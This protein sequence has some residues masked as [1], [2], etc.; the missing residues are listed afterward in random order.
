MYASRD[1]PSQ[2]AY[3]CFLLT[4]SLDNVKYIDEHVCVMA[5]DKIFFFNPKVLIFFFFLH[6]NICC[7]YSLE[8]PQ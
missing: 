8:V 7:G 2:V 5:L 6:K 3:F 1:S 4:E